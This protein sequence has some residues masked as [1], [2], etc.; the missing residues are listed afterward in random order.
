MDTPWF[1]SG[2]LMELV[3]YGVTIQA[4]HAP[5]GKCLLLLFQVTNDWSTFSRD[6]VIEPP[7]SGL[8]VS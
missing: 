3:C 1:Y 6:P 5:A 8:P 4:M 7:A 2:I